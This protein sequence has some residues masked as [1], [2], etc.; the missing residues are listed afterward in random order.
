[1]KKFQKNEKYASIAFYAGVAVVVSFL[2][3]L[4]VINFSTVWS[5]IKSFFAVLSPFIYGF[6][7]AY[8]LQPVMSFYERTVFAFKKAKKNRWGLR[9]ALSIVLTFLTVAAFFTVIMYAVI[10]QIVASVDNLGSQLNSYIA[11]LQSFADSTVERFS[12]GLLGKQY[13]T[14]SEL[15]KEHDITFSIKDILNNSY[16]SMQSA[17]DYVLSYGTRIVSE[18]INI[19]MGCFVAVYFLVNKEKVSAQIKKLMAAVLSRR[20]YLNVI[21]LARYTHK[22]FGGFIVGNLIDS[23]IVGFVSLAVMG[24]FKIPYYPLLAVIVGVTNFIPTFGPVIGGVVGGFLLLIVS[25]SKLIGFIIILLVIQQLDGNI[26]SPKIIGE[27]VG[28]SSMWVMIAIVAAGGFFGFAGMII[29][30]PA[31]AVI[32]VLVKQWAERRLKGRNMPYHTGF[33]RNDPPTEKTVDP[34]YVIIGKDVPV[35]EI[36]AD[37]DVGDEIVP[38]KPPLSDRIKAFFKKLKQL[39]NKKN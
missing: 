15:L 35:E 19:L 6:V 13:L 1:M 10:P 3:V 28:L 20:T 5:H 31:T 25:P 34:A 36:T 7:F 37:Y 23:I 24:I 12:E 26:L 4:A 2:I 9:R 18:I 30:V 33:Y 27:S 17:L 8:I 14:L 32:Y 39:K 11:N 38:P 22:T 29:G 16:V 21:R